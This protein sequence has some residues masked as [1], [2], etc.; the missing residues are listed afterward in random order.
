MAAQSTT[1]ELT[2]TDPGAANTSTIESLDG[3]SNLKPPCE[4]QQPLITTRCGTSPWEINFDRNR[5]QSP[6]LRL[7]DELLLQ[8]MKNIVTAADLF[9]IRQVS[10]KF[11]RIAQGEDF[12]D[13]RCW[14]VWWFGSAVSYKEKEMIALR[15][16][17]AA[18]CDPCLQKRTSPT[19]HEDRDYFRT[20][21]AVYCAY[22]EEHHTRIAFSAQQRHL[23]PSSRRCISSYSFL[24]LCPHLV[25]PAHSI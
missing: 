16:K 7:P 11:W 20:S 9:M 15:A 10:F 2:T 21:E 5:R 18:F 1:A 25:V 19:F 17:R 12:S 4:D 3:D 23:P 24:R 13:L 6:I 14:D 8:I 22:C